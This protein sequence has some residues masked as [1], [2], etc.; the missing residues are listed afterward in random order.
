MQLSYR[1]KVSW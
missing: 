1:L